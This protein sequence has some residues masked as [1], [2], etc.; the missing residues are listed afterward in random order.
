MF[1][2]SF[3]SMIVVVCLVGVNAQAVVDLTSDLVLKLGLDG[4]LNDSSGNG[5]LQGDGLLYFGAQYVAGRTGEAGDQAVDFG[6][7]TG[8]LQAMVAP[9]GAG[10]WVGQGLNDQSAV[11][12]AMWIKMD[13][14]PTADAGVISSREWFWGDTNL[15][16][17]SYFGYDKMYLI[18]VQGAVPAENP[19]AAIPSAKLGEWMHVAATYD[20]VAGEA[21]IYLDGVLAGQAPVLNPNND[22]VVDIGNYT[23]GGNATAGRWFDGQIDD[24]VIYSRALNVDEVNALIPE[25]AT[26]TLLALGMSAM[27]MRRRRSH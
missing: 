23:L 10:G 9:D 20:V 1:K 16:F 6:A 7:G 18:N 3:I 24:V 25:P 22:R 19:V 13:A 26:L 11:T 14:Y 27:V 12:Y 2:K 4:N 5:Y 17:H 15:E 8:L 21:K